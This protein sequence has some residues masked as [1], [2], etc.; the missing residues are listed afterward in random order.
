[1]NWNLLPDIHINQIEKLY[2]S[3][4]LAMYA[5]VE[6]EEAPALQNGPNET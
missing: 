3:K 1:M 5:E 4:N 2:L 6:V